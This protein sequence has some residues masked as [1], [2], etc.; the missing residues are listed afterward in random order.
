MGQSPKWREAPARTWHSGHKQITWYIQWAFFF[1][2]FGFSL[3]QDSKINV[4]QPELHVLEYLCTTG[5]YSRSQRG[6]TCLLLREHFLHRVSSKQQSLYSSAA[7]EIKV[8]RSKGIERKWIGKKNL[9]GSF[10]TI[11]TT[12][13]NIKFEGTD[14]KCRETEF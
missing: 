12:Q 3:L 6:A 14:M 11:Q 13:V 10:F 5:S 4:I 9:Q 1:F 2:S 8:L 7:K